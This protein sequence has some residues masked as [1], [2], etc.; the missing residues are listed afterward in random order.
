[1][2]IL[3]IFYS[4]FLILFCLKTTFLI[5]GTAHQV[6]FSF[7]IINILSVII[8]VLTSYALYK[9]YYSNKNQ[10]ALLILLSFVVLT[11][12][13]YT[14]DIFSKRDAKNIFAFQPLIGLLFSL[15]FLLNISFKKNRL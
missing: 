6:D 3:A 9:F 15:L 14:Y 11:F 8:F 1:M 10:T 12:G 7:S 2:K 13:Y 4:M 5:L